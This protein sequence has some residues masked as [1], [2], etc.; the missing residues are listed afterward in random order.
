MFQAQ[1]ITRFDFDGANA[2][3]QQS[4]QSWN[5]RIEQGIFVRQSRGLDAGH[6]A[7]PSPRHL[8]VARPGQAHGKFVGTLAAVNEVRVAIDEAWRDQGALAGMFGQLS[9]IV[10]QFGVSAHPGNGPLLDHNGRI[11]H[12]G[13]ACA[14]GL[15]SQMQ[16]MPN[17]IGAGPRIRN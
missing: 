13:Q 2:L 6:N 12:S 1:A 9:V 5:G 4:L 17:A 7:A 11:R 15:R 16:V 8:F 3:G 10:W 14:Q